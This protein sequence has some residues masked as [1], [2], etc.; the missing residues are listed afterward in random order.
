VSWIIRE[1]VACLVATLHC[2]SAAAHKL[3]SELEAQGGMEELV[4]ATFL[5]IRFLGEAAL[6]SSVAQLVE[7]GNA[8]GSVG[9]PGTRRLATRR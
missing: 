5:A 1:T 6:N 2:S 9:Q 4:D 8:M 3:L 7:N